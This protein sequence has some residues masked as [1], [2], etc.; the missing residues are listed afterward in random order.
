MW[1][2]ELRK[3]VKCGKGAAEDGEK[4]GEQEVTSFRAARPVVLLA[5]GKLNPIMLGL[6]YDVAKELIPKP[7]SLSK[8]RMKLFLFKYKFLGPWG[9]CV[10]KSGVGPR[11]LSI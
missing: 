11:D 2:K 7:E 1:G 8:P 9:S 3:H 4:A 5:A 6:R 10:M